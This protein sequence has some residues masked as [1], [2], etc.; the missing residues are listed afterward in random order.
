MT[1]KALRDNYQKKQNIRYRQKKNNT[2][3]NKKSLLPSNTSKVKK[4]Q[5]LNKFK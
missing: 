5:S 3:I 1:L 4:N 2:V